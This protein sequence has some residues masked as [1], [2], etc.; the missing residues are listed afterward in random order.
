MR[1]MSERSQSQRAMKLRDPERK[2]YCRF[3]VDK[4]EAIDYRDDKRLIRCM[5][6]QGKILPRRLTGVCSRHQRELATAIKY[7][8]HLALLPFKAEAMR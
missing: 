6:E 5:S 4:S 2:R 8:R 3:C 7:A 1:T